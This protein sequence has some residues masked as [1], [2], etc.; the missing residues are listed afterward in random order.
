MTL[1]SA[2]IPPTYAFP[3]GATRAAPLAAGGVYKA[4]TRLAWNST[5]TSADLEGANPD[6]IP[7]VRFAVPVS[8]T[9]APV[10]VATYSVAV[11]GETAVTGD[12]VPWQSPSSTDAAARYNVP[13][14]TNLFPALGTT[15]G[16]L[17]V[18]ISVSVTDAA[19]NSG[20]ASATVTFN[21]VGP[22]LYIAE[23]A[24]Y[25][26]YMDVRSTHPYRVATNTFATLWNPDSM[27]FYDGAVRLVR[28]VVTNPASQPVALRTS[29]AQASEGSWRSVE[30]W[31]STSWRVAPTDPCGF[32]KRTNYTLDGFSFSTCEAVSFPLGVP[33]ACWGPW[34]SVAQ[35]AQDKV[36]D[37][38]NIA[39]KWSC[40]PRNRYPH[41]ATNSA[42]SADASVAV[43]AGPLP[44][45]GEVVRPTT[46]G[47]YSI[48]PAAIGSTPGTLVVYVTR[49]LRAPRSIPLRWNPVTQSGQYQQWLEEI[50]VYRSF[51][52]DF[53]TV[54]WIYETWRAMRA[55]STAEDR[56]SGSVMFETLAVGGGTTLSGEV[57][58][59]PAIS[60]TDR[61]VGTH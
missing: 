32:L 58:M 31:T 41:V 8:S 38:G 45:G 25:P 53:L 51:D 27:N 48:V 46:L 47:S 49:P 17:F 39:T 14:A 7:F 36:H 19:G 28:L 34:T 4:G 11:N 59:L 57:S 44:G 33:P 22:P 24:A 6:N 55:L 26:A 9:Q 61:V 2:S 1:A 30:T 15:P 52:V 12:L 5:P 43:F 56:L 23:D 18:E 60:F 16:V 20:N 54:D 3:V 13:L 50:G 37:V 10:A 42:S 29:Y 35:P 21:I 40:K